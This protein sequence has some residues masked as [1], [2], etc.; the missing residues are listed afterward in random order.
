ML[1]KIGI[2]S[3]LLV[4]L[5]GY[6]LACEILTEGLPWFFIG[7]TYSIQLDAYGTA[8]FVGTRLRIPSIRHARS[9]SA[10]RMGGTGGTCG[11]SGMLSAR[12]AAL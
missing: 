1:R 10:S 5:A 9:G 8:P 6:G 11:T 7:H 4:S 3:L 2:I 12:C